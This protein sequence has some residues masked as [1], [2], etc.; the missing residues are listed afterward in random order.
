MTNKGISY[1]L[2]GSAALYWWVLRGVNA[3]VFKFV[4]L[5]M[6]GIDIAADTVQLRATFLF[7]NPLLISLFIRY[8]QGDIYIMNQLAAQID[9]NVLCDLKS[10][11]YTYINVP[12][13]VYIS[14]LSAGVLENIKSGDIRTLLIEFS[15]KIGIGKERT[16]G[17]PARVTLTWDDLVNNK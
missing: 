8:I 12:V 16:V 7:R 15:G 5:R 17:V 3:L 11:T 1:I 9:S 10:R 4:Q 14:G 6:T 13:S 2:L